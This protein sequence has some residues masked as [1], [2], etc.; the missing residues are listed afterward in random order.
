MIWLD[1]SRIL[2]IFAVVLLHTAAGVVIGSDVGSETWWIG[3]LYDSF[4][5][6]CVPVF[7]MISGALLLDPSKKEDLKTFYLKRLSKI[8]IPLLFWSAFFLLWAAFKGEIK[9]EPLSLLD[10]AKRLLSG[11]PHYHMW[12]LYMIVILYLF[13]P[14]LRKIITSSTRIEIVVIASFTLLL[15]ALNAISEKA[16]PEKPTIFINWFLSYIPFFFIGYLIRAS[17]RSYPKRILWCA[18]IASF[19][20]TAIGCYSVAKKEGLNA[21]LYFYAYLSITV[22]PMSLSIMCILRSWSRPI[23]NL[24]TTK[25][26]SALTL[27]IY[28]VHPIFLETIGHVGYGALDFYPAVS[29]PLIAVVVFC[30]SLIVT[31]LIN[32]I[33]YLARV[34]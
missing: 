23:L 28:L 19:I 6:W 3:N 29:I 9:G 8:L 20:L 25:K 16:L 12:F 4:V 18:F 27:G 17:D 5:R 24:N 34:I 11:K 26:L 32:K 10:L 30:F 14:F 22:I 2:A 21:G 31:W 13:T 15:S 33:P 1:N 7:V